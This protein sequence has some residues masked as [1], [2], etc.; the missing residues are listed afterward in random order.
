MQKLNWQTRQIGPYLMSFDVA[1]AYHN[2]SI[3]TGVESLPKNFLIQ[4]DSVND[5]LIISICYS[6][7]TDDKYV[8]I[9]NKEL[10]ATKEYKFNVDKSSGLESL[11]WIKPD[12]F[13][14]LP[15]YTKDLPEPEKVHIDISSGSFNIELLP[16]EMRLFKLDGDVAIKEPLQAPKLSCKSGTY[17]GE[18]LVEI[19]S[20]DETAEIFYTTDGSYPTYT[21]NKYT[22]P[23]KIGNGREFGL[24]NIKAI[25]IRG[26]E[27][28]DVSTGEYVISDGSE[29]V[30][31]GKPV[32]FTGET[33]V[34]QGSTKPKSITDGGFDPYNTYGSKNNQPCLRGR[35]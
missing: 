19:S 16:G 26:N 13:D 7:K 18:Q 6:K 28:S 15:D 11:T 33:E 1:H 3:P 8:M 31:L 17:L 25:A 21:S 29:N 12:S 20:P 9:F 32:T 35:K 27:I 2:G 30:A 4:P 10:A 23:I 24:F 14:T 34:W 22:G 5:E